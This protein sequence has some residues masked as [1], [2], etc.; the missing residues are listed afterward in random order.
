MIYPQAGP[1]KA[2]TT[3]PMVG[4]QSILVRGVKITAHAVMHNTPTLAYEVTTADGYRIVH[5][6]DAQTSTSLPV[7]EGIDLLLLNGWINGSGLVSNLTDMKSSLD[8]MRPDAM[9]PGHFEELSQLA[10]G[11][12]ADRYRFL[13]ALPLQ[14][15]SLGR[16][17]TVVMT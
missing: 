15:G 10:A 1:L 2:N 5:T 7:L 17:R 14:N 16:S 9:V 4:G 12:S 11:P 3:L 13:D 8:K 6:G